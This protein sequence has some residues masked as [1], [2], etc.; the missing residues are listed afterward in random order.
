MA[1]AGNV[2]A[3]LTRSSASTASASERIGIGRS[4]GIFRV[5]KATMQVAFLPILKVSGK[6]LGKGQ[7][8]LHES[9]TYVRFTDAG[10]A[11]LN[12]DSQ[13]ARPHP[14]VMRPVHGTALI[15]VRSGGSLF[16]TREDRK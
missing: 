11:L 4:S 6:E 3:K 9:G 12:S 8:W 7:L 5:E 16:S 15:S 14:S 2:D 10:A 1:A 13:P